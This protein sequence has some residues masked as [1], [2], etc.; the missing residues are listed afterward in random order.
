MAELADLIGV[1]RGM[2]HA[3]RNQ[4]VTRPRTV[5]QVRR[6]MAL[7]LRDEKDNPYEGYTDDDLVREVSRRL[8]RIRTEIEHVM[9]SDS[10][11]LEPDSH[12]DGNGRYTGAG[13]PPEDR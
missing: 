9:D 4:G 11:D 6:V 5:E 3:Y 10:N 1:S 8:A 13:G 12:G 7:W 2:I